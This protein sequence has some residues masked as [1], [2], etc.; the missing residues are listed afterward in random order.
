MNEVI[1]KKYVRVE[2]L[3]CA[4]C[5]RKIE[6]AVKKIDGVKEANLSFMAEKMLV[7][8]DDGE[9]FDAIFDEIE[10]IAKNVEPECEVSY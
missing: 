6:T 1:M 10:K 5:A 4:N 3:C 9:D 7:E 8:Y 2:N